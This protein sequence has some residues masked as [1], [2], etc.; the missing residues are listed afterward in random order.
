MA[1]YKALLAFNFPSLA[2]PTPAP[3][4]RGVCPFSFF[5]AGYIAVLACKVLHD[6]TLKSFDFIMFIMAYNDL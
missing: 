1:A 3:A 6:K 5:C 2:D 4:N